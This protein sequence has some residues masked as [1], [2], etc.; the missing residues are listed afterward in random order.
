LTACFLHAAEKNFFEEIRTIILDLDRSDIDPRDAL[1]QLIVFAEPGSGAT[2]LLRQQAVL[3]AQ[4]GYPTLVSNPM[5][6]N[7]RIRSLGEVVG[8]LQDI[9][10]R[11]RKGHGTGRG[12]L[13]V[14]IF[15]DKD[16]GDLPDS[17]TM[18]RSLASIGREVLLVRAFERS[19]DEMRDARGAFLL[20]AAISEPELLALGDHLRS[21]AEEHSL[22]PMPTTEEW[23]AYHRGLSQ[24]ARYS[25]AIRST[26]L[27]EVPHLFL[28]GIQPF[29]SDR[30]TDANSIEQYYF[31][32]WDRNESINLKSRFLTTLSDAA[33]DLIL[34][35][36]NHHTV[37]FID[38][39]KYFWNGKTK[40]QTFKV[41]I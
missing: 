33:Q 12:R 18:A 40:G 5:P 27:E 23:R 29:I 2:T 35:R 19:R 14:A 10:W 36:L 28:I 9:W 3:T 21:F 7:L 24:L 39:S 1:R 11:E 15:V 6:R 13:P 37:R 8:S 4:M 16:A 25:P 32:R 20:P 31:Q 17:R 41:G 26:D 30:V 34:L 22:T 38:Q